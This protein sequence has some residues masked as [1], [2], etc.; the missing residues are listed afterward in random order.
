[1]SQ[2]LPDD[3]NTA[4]DVVKKVSGSSFYAAMRMLPRAQRAAMFEIYSFCRMVDDIAD[5]TGPAA[6]RMERLQH[7]RDNI[8][9]LYAGTAL[10]QLRGLRSAI[11]DFGLRREDF[12][13]IIDG[14]KMD[15]ISPIR[16]PEIS[17]LDLYCDRVAS[18]VG[19]LSVRVFGIDEALGI[20]LAHH[21]GRALQLTNILR[22]LDEDAS[23]GR[24]YLPSE[25]L[26]EAGI[27]ATEPA[28][29]LSDPAI[30]GA[31]AFIAAKAHSHFQE[32]NAIMA[33]CPRRT[34]RAPNIMSEVYKLILD[35]LE[36][37][38]WKA[39]RHPVRIG[40]LRLFWILS[41]HVF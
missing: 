7:W 10:P 27:A 13:A 41:R 28:M 8:Y 39:P 6:G 38:G 18:A 31:C 9:A 33:R 40:R 24:L 12:L 1:M 36:R 11:Q 5:D 16:A 26:R 17:T 14:M 29:V 19:R 34:T 4:D 25:A 30:P 32:A 22:D 20:A 37:R 15:V 2:A 21:L 3:G 35:A 23:V